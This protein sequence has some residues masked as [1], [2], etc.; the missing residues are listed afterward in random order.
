MDASQ[1][2]K[3]YV[4]VDLGSGFDTVL[5]RVFVDTRRQRLTMWVSPAQANTAGGLHGGALATFADMQLLAL[6]WGE[7]HSPTVSLSVDY[8]AP[9]PT[10][11]WL[12][13]EVTKL[14]ATRTLLFT[15]AM[16]HAEG[17]IVARSSAIYRN[18]TDL[19]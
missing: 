17:Q 1:P 15:Q 19:R 16:I 8:L 13:A 5:G 14:R 10:G 7:P 2:P 9:V 18:R 6:G 11:V 3:G 4:A 12:E